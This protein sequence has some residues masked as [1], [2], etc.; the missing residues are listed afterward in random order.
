MKVKMTQKNAIKLRLH[1]IG[2]SIQLIIIVFVAGCYGNDDFAPYTRFTRG[3]EKGVSIER[4]DS[5]ADLIPEA[6]EI[7]RY[8][9]PDTTLTGIN[10]MSE[11]LGQIENI[12]FV[13]A[14]PHGTLNQLTVVRV[15]FD[16]NDMIFYNVKFVQ[17]HGRRVSAV[18]EPI[19]YKYID[20]TFDDFFRLIEDLLETD[21]DEIDAEHRIELNFERICVSGRG[22]P[23]VCK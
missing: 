1:K 2:V 4:I 11:D 10:F 23:R 22:M 6:Y 19:S 14:M 5:L 18:T 21:L 8:F 7:A 3:I 9:D 12:E 13:F 16:M 17:G 15:F 20:M